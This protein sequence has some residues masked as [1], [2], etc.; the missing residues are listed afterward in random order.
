MSENKQDIRA[1]E[2][3]QLTDFFV[4]HGEKPFRAKQVNE[5]LWK[6]SARS[7]DDMTNLS[8]ATRELMKDHFVINGI[9]IGESQKSKESI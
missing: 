7:F 5:W 3:E 2:L 9:S 4:E 1:V 6:K 8:L